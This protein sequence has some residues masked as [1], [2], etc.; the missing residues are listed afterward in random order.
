MSISDVGGTV[1]ELVITCRT[2]GHDGNVGELIEAG[3]PVALD[4][5]YTVSIDVEQY[6]DVFGQALADERGL[7]QHPIPVKVRGICIFQYE[8]DEDGNA[9]EVGGG[10]CFGSDHSKKVQLGGCGLV[11]KVDE[12]AKQVHVL[13]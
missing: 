10:V 4:G 11:L 9:P 8:L 12:A 3:D 5:P 13:L 7:S 2:P 1:T 6:R